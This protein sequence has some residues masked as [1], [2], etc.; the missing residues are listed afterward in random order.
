MCVHAYVPLGVG[1]NS[2]GGSQVLLTNYFSR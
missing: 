2:L 1:N